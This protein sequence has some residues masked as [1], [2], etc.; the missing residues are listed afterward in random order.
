MSELPAPQARGD[1]SFDMRVPAGLA[2]GTYVIEIEA[3]SG[4]AAPRV[5]RGF[6]IAN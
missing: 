2:R 1:G 6:A 3:S 5:E 4:E